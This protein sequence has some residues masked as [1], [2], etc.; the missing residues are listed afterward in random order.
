MIRK[1]FLFS[2]TVGFAAA[3]TGGLISC[4]D[5]SENNNSSSIS[6]ETTGAEVDED[7]SKTTITLVLDK[8]AS[9]DVTGKLSVGGTAA[10]NGDYS[11][12]DL[13]FT[14]D[15][16]ETSLEIDIEIIDETLIEADEDELTITFDDVS[17][18]DIGEEN[19]TYTLTINDN[20]EYPVEGEL[21]IDLSWTLGEGVDID[22]ADLDLWFLVNVVFDGYGDIESFD[23]YEKLSEN[24]FG[25][26]SIKLTADDPDQ[27][28]YIAIYYYE[29]EVDVDFTLTFNSTLWDNEIIEDVFPKEYVGYYSY[30]VDPLIKSDND[31]TFRSASGKKSEPQFYLRKL[32][33][34]LL[35]KLKAARK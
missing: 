29:G 2:C 16:G 7:V 35:S 32:D 13:S 21:Q 27:D 15:A 30:F 26:E 11:I 28:Y 12:D 5:D 4:S 31:Y 3:L 19:D 9:E 24:D 23:F 18:A 14:I 25:F 10:L 22:E 20:D 8:A 34:Q 33:A 17:G 1:I 6:F